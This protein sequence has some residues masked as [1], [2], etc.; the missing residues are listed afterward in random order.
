MAKIC[1]NMEIDQA[2]HR[3]WKRQYSGAGVSDLR[4]ITQVREKNGLKAL[5]IQFGAEIIQITD[6]A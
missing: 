1:R 5:L 4:E 6:D 2:T 3:L